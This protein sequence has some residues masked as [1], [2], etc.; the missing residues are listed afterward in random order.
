PLRVAFGAS[1]LLG[2][3]LIATLGAEWSQA[4]SEADAGAGLPLATADQTWRVGGGIEW[5]GRRD[6]TR[7]F[8]I[9]IGG[10]WANLPYHL[11]DEEKASEWT[12]DRKSTRLNS[13]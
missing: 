3:E 7:T 10:S 4:E 8:P 6:A 1:G 2:T 12:I 13:S 9:R 11:A 5:S